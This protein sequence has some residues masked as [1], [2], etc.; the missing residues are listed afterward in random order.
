MEPEPEPEP[1]PQPQPQPEP[2]PEP[3]PEP[4]AVTEDRLV[5]ITFSHAGP[6]GVHWDR[7]GQAITVGRIQ[8]GSAAA[9][10]KWLVVGQRLRAVNSQTVEGLPQPAIIQLL[11]ARPV[12]LQLEST[13][14]ASDEPEPE[15]EL[16]PMRGGDEPNSQRSSTVAEIGG[17]E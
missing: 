12:T 6:M 8:P 2:E 14:R 1:E 5:Q 13:K 11:K 7:G 17:S 4:K 9:A 16:E 10:Q 3:E 15:P